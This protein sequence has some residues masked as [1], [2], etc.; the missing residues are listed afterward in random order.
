MGSLCT[1]IGHEAAL[2]RY[3]GATLGER[4]Q[5]GREARHLSGH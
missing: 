2:S 5:L 4:S 3:S 1:P